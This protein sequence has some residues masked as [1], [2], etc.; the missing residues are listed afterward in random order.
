[1]PVP[2]TMG[3][4]GR[5][6]WKRPSSGSGSP[7]ALKPRHIHEF[8]RHFRRKVFVVG[9]AAALA[10]AFAATSAHGLEMI[11]TEIIPGPESS[12]C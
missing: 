5:A 10:S 8:A 9:D 6:D 2:I 3:D 4:L 11:V 1:M 12:Y 7:C